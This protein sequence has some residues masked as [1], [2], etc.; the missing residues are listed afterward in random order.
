M[1]SLLS[2]QNVEKCLQHMVVFRD[3]FSLY[4]KVSSIHVIS[5]ITKLQHRVVFTL[6]SQQSTVTE[7]WSVTTVTFRQSGEQIISLTRKLM[8]PLNKKFYFYYLIWLSLLIFDT[9]Y[10]TEYYKLFCLKGFQP[11]RWISLC[12]VWLIFPRRAELILLELYVLEQEVEGDLKIS[13]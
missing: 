10:G 4:M 2:A 8:R 7:F 3:I 12:C 9:V 5:V 6:T 13:I 1:Q 11:T